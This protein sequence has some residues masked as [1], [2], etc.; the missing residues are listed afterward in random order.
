MT[1]I[2]TVTVPALQN[3]G[4][5]IVSY[6]GSTADAFAEWGTNVAANFQAVMA[7][8]PGAAAEGLSAA[9]KSVVDWINA[10]SP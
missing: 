7:Y 1:Y 6:L 2:S 10:T 8:L 9:G 3:S 4:A 5:S